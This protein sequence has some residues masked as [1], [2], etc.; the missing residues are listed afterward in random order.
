[1]QLVQIVIKV[2]HRPTSRTNA[3][4]QGVTCPLKMKCK[5]S[6]WVKDLVWLVVELSI[7]RVKLIVC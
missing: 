5:M 3:V 1:M 4:R 7:I 6:Q 2:I